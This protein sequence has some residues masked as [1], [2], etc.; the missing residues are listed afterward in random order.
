MTQI[1]QL[2]E[3]EIEAR[4]HVT[5]SRPVGFLL[6]T[7]ARERDAFSVQF[8]DGQMFLTALLAVDADKGGLVFDCSGSAETNRLLL[9]A[10]R[11]VFVGRPGG[12]HV[13]FATGRATEIRFEGDRAFSVALP[14]KVVRLQ[15]RESFRIDTPRIRPLEFFGRLPEG[16]LLKLPAHDISVSGIGLA[17]PELPPGLAPGQVLD[18]CHFHLPEDRTE[19]F[20][21]CVVT[22]FTEQQGR[23][24]NRQWRIGLH[25]VDL[26]A[27]EENRIQRYITHVERE[28][29]E[30]S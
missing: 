30:L 21:R 14:Q 13:Q 5:G 3:S 22:H 11:I 27:S 28:R 6:A 8:G 18:N 17:A 23:G 19:L 10:A 24:G 25:F 16:G 4:F 15:R 12:V 1:A 26:P 7:Y 9:D 2:S 29:H 20:F